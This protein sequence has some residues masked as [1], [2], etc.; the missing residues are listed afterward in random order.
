[1]SLKM[2]KTNIN[3][4]IRRDIREGLVIHT[5]EWRGYTDM[6]FNNF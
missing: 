1:M 4:V 6:P 2:E 5:G 3:V